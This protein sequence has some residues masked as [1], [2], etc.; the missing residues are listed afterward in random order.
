MQWKKKKK[1]RLSCEMLFKTCPIKSPSYLTGA[2]ELAHF[3]SSSSE[4]ISVIFLP[5]QWRLRRTMFCPGQT[6][7]PVKAS[8]SIRGV[9]STALRYSLLLMLCIGVPDNPLQT[10][11]SNNGQSTTT[12]WRAVRANREDRVAKLEWASNG[13]LGRAVIG[14]VR[15]GIRHKYMHVG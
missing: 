4:S 15:E 8:S 12:L 7:I 6:K 10:V 2:L 11:V 9:F 3:T 14:K 5:S 13:G 1:T